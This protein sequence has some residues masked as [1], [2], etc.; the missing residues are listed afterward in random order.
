[1][2]RVGPRLRRRVCRQVCAKEL[3]RHPSAG[4]G[5]GRAN[6]QRTDGCWRHE[7]IGEIHIQ[8]TRQGVQCRQCRVGLTRLDPA[9]IGS[10][11]IAAISQFFLGDFLLGAQLLDAQAQRFTGIGEIGCHPGNVIYVYLFIHTLIRTLAMDNTASVPTGVIG[12]FCSACGTKLSNAVN[13]CSSC[14][15]QLSM[16]MTNQTASVQ[17]VA[18]S[19]STQDQESSQGGSEIG[20]GTAWGIYAA[21]VGFVSVLNHHKAHTFGHLNL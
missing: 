15:N 5:A 2:E 19:P 11:Q 4:K 17:T 18:P 16:V 3:A 6:P 7:Q 20:L 9:H 13:F 1:M 14:G 21:A 10:K 8:A 12:S